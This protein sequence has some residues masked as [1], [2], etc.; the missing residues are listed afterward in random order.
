MKKIFIT[1]AILSVC[2][3]ARAV[4]VNS[5]DP[6]LYLQKIKELEQTVKAQ[7][8]KIDKL[9]ATLEDAKKEFEKLQAEAT[10]LREKNAKLQEQIGG[11]AS[12][13]PFTEEETPLTMVNAYPEKYIGKT[14]IAIGRIAVRDY[15]NFRYRYAKE[16]HICLYFVELRP[17]NSQTGVSMDLYVRREI[18]K[19]LVEKIT[20]AVGAGHNSE[21]IRVKASILENRYD[22]MGG[23]GMAELINWQFLSSDKKGWQDWAISEGTAKPDVGTYYDPNGGI[24][25]RDKKRDMRWLNYMYKEFQ[26]K[27]AFVDGKYIYL[28][29]AS[30]ERQQGKVLQVLN[31]GEAIIYQE[32]Y[33]A[34]RQRP[35]TP[36][37]PEGMY[38]RI[39]S[40]L[41]AG[42]DRPEIYFHIKGYKGTLID[43]QQFSNV[44]LI[45]CGTYKYTSTDGANRIIQSFAVYEPLTRERFADA[46]NSGFI[47][48]KQIKVGDK[49]VE[50][51]IP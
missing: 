45:S 38:R 7:Q 23:G 50:Q 47:L 32:G 44:T 22:P 10:E 43:G 13:V 26:N 1:L 37:S 48:T 51:S 31:D 25:Y 41:I 4:D 34:L 9:A 30:V 15:Y 5:F 18:S 20:K 33:T 14:F 19:N 17:D 49:T 35:G 40:A 6:N 42:P 21:I 11:S 8:Q 29:D 39:Q 28:A 24:I 27:I 36:E 16:S 46:L 2:Q 12:A 3:I